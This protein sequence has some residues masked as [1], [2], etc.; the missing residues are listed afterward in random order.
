[1]VYNRLYLHHF[2][3]FYIGDEVPE[4]G[5]PV[6]EKGTH[7]RQ[8]QAVSGDQNTPHHGLNLKELLLLKVRVHYCTKILEKYKTQCPRNEIKFYEMLVFSVK[9]D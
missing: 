8:N 6:S 9:I 7:Q 2:K 5:E 3:S 1:M 4:I